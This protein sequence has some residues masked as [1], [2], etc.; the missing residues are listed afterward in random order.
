MRSLQ[1]LLSF[2]ELEN[3]SQKLYNKLLIGKHDVQYTDY[4]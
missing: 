2:F 4:L 1:T 3:I